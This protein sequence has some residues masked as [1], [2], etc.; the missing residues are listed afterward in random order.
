MI[1][2]I[3]DQE[4]YSDRQYIF[5]RNFTGIVFNTTLENLQY[6]NTS[7]KN[8][9]FKH[10]NLNH[11]DFQNCT[12]DEAEFINV[13]TSITFFENSTIKNSRFVDTDL[14]NHHFVNCTLSNNT[15]MSLISD[16]IVDFDYNIYLDDL[17]ED[18]LAWAGS[19]FPALLFMGFILETAARPP[20][21]FTT[22]GTA[23]IT[24]IGIFFWTNTFV[25]T[26]IELTVKIML[27]CAVNAITMVVVEAYPCHLRYHCSLLP[28]R[29]PKMLVLDARPTA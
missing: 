10:I 20:L 9:T 29:S 13:K 12:V 28:Q 26:L 5:N 6:K 7:F 27:M 2:Q 14:T 4:Y 23:S 21:I 25:V 22:M 3:K 11:V 16:C 17:Y 19:M 18:T 1:K 15:F 24:S 8:V